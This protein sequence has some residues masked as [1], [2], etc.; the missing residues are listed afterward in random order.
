MNNETDIGIK[1]S[2][3]VS[4]NGKLEKLAQN[5]ST[6]KAV[7][8]GINTN[9]INSLQDSSDATKDIQKDTSTMAKTMKLAFNYSAIKVFARQIQGL[10]R[11]ITR[12]TNKSSEYLENY[13][14]FQVAFKGSYESAEKFVNKITEMYGLDESRITRVVGLFKQLGN[15]MNVSEETGEK[16]AKLMTQMSLDISSL[17]NVDFERATSVLQ[18][19]FSGQTKPIRGT[20]GADITQATLQT[21]LDNLGIDR[22]VNQLTF[23]EKRLVILISLTQ[24]LRAA[25]NDLGRTIE[26]PANQMKILSEQWERLSR[27]LGNLFLPILKAILPYLNAILMVLTAIISSIAR[28]FG[29]KKEDFDYFDKPAVSVGKLDAGLGKATKSAGKLKKALSGLRGFDKLNVIQTPAESGGG[30][31]GGG[32]GGTGI[33]GDILK[34]FNDAY[35]S[36]NKQL[37]NVKMKATKI[38]DTIMEWLGFTKHVDEKTGE[39]SFKFDHITGGTVLGALATGGVIFKGISKIVK[40]LQKIGLLKFPIIS[41]LVKLVS[42]SGKDASDAIDA[43]GSVAGSANKVS[44]EL[45]VPNISTILKGL[46]DVAIIIGGCTA[47][48]AAMGLIAKIPGVSDTVHDG[49]EITSQVFW[50]IAKIIIP[51]AAMSALVGV[52]GSFGVKQFVAGLADLAI[53]ILGCEAVILAAGTIASLPYVGGFISTGIDT[54]QKVIRGIADV[55]LPI[56]VIGSAL[57]IAGLGGGA[58]AAAIATGLADFALIIGGLEVV[59]AALGALNSIPGFGWLVDKGTDLLLK[60]AD[61]IGDFAG[62]LVSSLA[63]SVAKSLPKIGTK[64]SEFMINAMPFFENASKI[65][66]NAMQGINALSSALLKLTANEILDSLTKWFTGGSSLTEFGKDLAT[67]GPYFAKYSDSV[68]SVDSKVITSTTAAAK[69]LAAFAHEIPNK[70]GLVSQFTGDNTVSDFG[71]DLK[72]FGPS[73]KTYANSVSGINASIVKES[74]DAAESVAAFSKLIPNRGGLVSLFT[75]DNTLSKWGKDL[76]SFGP[77]F[78][79]YYSSIAGI[80]ASIVED[81]GNAVKTLAKF[82]SLVPNSGG[83]GSLF[84]GDNKISS[85]GKQLAKF[86]EHF[87]SYYSEIKSINTEKVDTV[88]ESLVQLVKQAKKI[89]DDGTKSTIKDFGKN[90]KKAAPDIRAYYENSLSKKEGESIGKEFGKAIADAIVAKF[91]SVKLPSL[92]IVSTDSNK[93]IATYNIKA[94]AQGG[95]PKVGQLFVANENGPELVD[96]IG[97]QSFVANQKQIASFIDNKLA[98]SNASS[99]QGTQ[100]YNIYLDKNNKIATYTL[101]QLQGMAK[102][103]GKPI[104]IGG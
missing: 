35:D 5:L 76:K 31:S 100:V 98:K 1:F 20:T 40:L 95:L 50:G 68:K 12:L 34:S 51:L 60:L 65:D 17:Y 13:N 26:S 87:K 36:Y 19:A 47:I 59:L 45:K 15:A 64:L 52:M 54:M 94:Y 97:G 104:T 81:T 16:L 25:T 69:S 32:A 55:I 63:D 74:S 4:G 23:A 43:A 92:K 56:G 37:S 11:E 101:E 30:A 53:I 57:A 72:S 14:L 9:T 79:S 27:A 46:A 67:F 49:I 24:Q 78:K 89:K 93:A 2:A 85:W 41:K 66:K 39:V 83:L 33:S 71:K 77:S 73:F 99:N 80:D 102:T 8:D 58:G 42:G 3:N 18:S 82:A 62:R 28:L 10:T 61:F 84:S 90:L 96:Q 86:G 103:N 88:T 21:T 22:M 70:G 44:K 7:A 38:R 6:I 29:Y 75:G 48:I 91:K